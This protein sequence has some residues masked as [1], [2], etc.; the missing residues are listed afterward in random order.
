[1]ADTRVDLETSCNSKSD[2]SCELFVEADAKNKQ[3]VVD[4]M[5]Q[6]RGLPDLRQM[7]GSAFSRWTFDSW[8]F[9]FLFVSEGTW[10]KGSPRGR[11][12]TSFVK[13]D[14]FLLDFQ[15]TRG[16]SAP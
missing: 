8:S 12:V 6:T 14:F 16:D 15:D 13:T 4:K 9:L 2:T 11:G 3:N 10:E 7:T 5:R 1:M